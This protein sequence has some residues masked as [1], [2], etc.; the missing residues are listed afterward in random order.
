MNTGSQP[1]EIF[2]DLLKYFDRS[3]TSIDSEA[4]KIKA[5]CIQG[6]KCSLTGQNLTSHIPPKA[7][8]WPQ[9]QRS[10]F[11]GLTLPF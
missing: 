7:S 1:P 11:V 5:Y 10:F 3:K 6:L 8:Q 2:K 4:Y 9:N